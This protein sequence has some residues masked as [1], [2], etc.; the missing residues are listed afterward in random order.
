MQRVL[1]HRMAAAQG[2]HPEAREE[3]EIPVTLVIDQVGALAS[4]IVPVE[5]QGGQYLDQLGVHESGV[6]VETLTL[7]V[8]Q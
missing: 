1:D 2:E 7:M 5:P 4:H 6:E 3:V 8:L